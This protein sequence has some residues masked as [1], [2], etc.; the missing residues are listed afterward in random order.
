LV[1]HDLT[2]GAEGEI[3]GRHAGGP[4]ATDASG[5]SPHSDGLYPQK[6][7]LRAHF[8]S[9]TDVLKMKFQVWILAAAALS[10]STSS[11]G[12]SGSFGG[13]GSGSDGPNSSE[14][15]FF[16]TSFSSR[17]SACD[18]A[19]SA[20]VEAGKRRSSIRDTS[21]GSCECSSTR[22]KLIYPQV[23]AQYFLE[24]GQANPSDPVDVYECTVDAKFTYR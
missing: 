4:P 17:A 8:F 3:L 12:Q 10:V 22:K 5:H 15:S 13:S 6:Q 16:G 19:K 1:N 2:I 18:K 24:T 23:Q 20:A 9:K 14:E 21:L 11:F 7:R